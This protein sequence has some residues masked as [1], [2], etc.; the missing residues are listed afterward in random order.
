ME[1]CGWPFGT[2]DVTKGVVFWVIIFIKK[3]LFSFISFSIYVFSCHVLGKNCPPP[4]KKKNPG[5]DFGP[6]RK[7]KTHNLEKQDAS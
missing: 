3:T 4:K 1:T 6:K 5:L 2:R 7:E